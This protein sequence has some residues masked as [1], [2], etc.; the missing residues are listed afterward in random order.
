MTDINIAT[1]TSNVFPVCINSGISCI[2][3]SNPNAKSVF[4]FT[5]IPNDA[6]FNKRC[7]CV[8]ELWRLKR[9]FRTFSVFLLQSAPEKRILLCG[10]VNLIMRKEF[11]V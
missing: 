3:I 4:A 1:P 11:Y 5:E 9:G 8:L 10:K 7:I 6:Q 2:R